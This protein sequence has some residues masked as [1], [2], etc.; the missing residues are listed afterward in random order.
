MGD[1]ETEDK[2][3][4]NGQS[5][6]DAM[7]RHLLDIKSQEERLEELLTDSEGWDK[8]NSAF[9]IYMEECFD[10]P[11]KARFRSARYG[12]TKRT[13][14]VLRITGSRNK[15]GVFCEIRFANGSK[16]EIPVYWIKPLNQKH[17]RNIAINDYLTWLPVKTQV[18]HVN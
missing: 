4:Q 5:D 6:D 12:N 1:T 17:Q 14:T 11:F 16:H 2:T 10:F 3:V 15:G 9:E 7:F 8:G 18:W 13:F